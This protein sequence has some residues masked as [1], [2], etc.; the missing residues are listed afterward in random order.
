M[1]RKKSLAR[2]DNTRKIF[3]LTWNIMNGC[4]LILNWAIRR[5]RLL[6]R[7]CCG[8]AVS[9]CFLLAV[10]EVVPA[11]NDVAGTLYTL[12]DNGGWSWFEDE[13]AIVDTAANKIIFSSVANGS[14]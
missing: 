3:P 9:I 14:G 12:N 8:S 13:R 5:I 4:R 7:R 1:F 6:G 2:A 11:A 10:Q